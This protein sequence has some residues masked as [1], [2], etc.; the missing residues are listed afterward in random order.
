MVKLKVVK[1]G[2]LIPIEIGSSFYKNLQDCSITWLNTFKDP[3]LVLTNIEKAQADPNF[4]LSLE[5]YNFLLLMTLV[6][7]IE[8]E[9]GKDESL[10]EYKYF[11]DS[12][13]KI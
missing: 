8:T 4:K 11:D 6:K 12:S 5:E 9:A 13:E 7:E 3:K 2:V 10:F 1:E